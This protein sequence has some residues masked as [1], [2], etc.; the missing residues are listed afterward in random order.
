LLDARPELLTAFLTRPISTLNGDR[1]AH[2]CACVLTFVITVLTWLRSM[3]L[4]TWSDSRLLRCAWATSL[5]GDTWCVMRLRVRVR[6]MLGRLS[7]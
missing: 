1:Y 3:P 4:C 6:D 7:W 2:V 5:C